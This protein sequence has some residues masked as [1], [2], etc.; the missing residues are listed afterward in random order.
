VLIKRERGR[1]G[2][3]RAGLSR[4]KGIGRGVGRH[5]LGSFFDKRTQGGNYD[6]RC[7]YT[8]FHCF[9]PL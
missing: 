3:E 2:H 9:T 7:G 4:R 6:V 1:S 5:K 8:A